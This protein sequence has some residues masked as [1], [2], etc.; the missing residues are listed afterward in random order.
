MEKKIGFITGRLYGKLPTKNGRIFDP[1]EV[2]SSSGV[3]S[4]PGFMP[5][6]LKHE[7]REV[8]FQ[9]TDI[10]A[11]D[12]DYD[13]F[14][15]DV[16]DTKSGKILLEKLNQGEKVSCGAK[17]IV[18][19]EKGLVSEFKLEAINIIQKHFEGK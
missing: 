14:Y 16:L 1:K 19:E 2:F 11:T 8:A 9:L 3:K 5:G 18:K 17:G 6:E 15:C 10:Q 7:D 12:K 4:I 13:I